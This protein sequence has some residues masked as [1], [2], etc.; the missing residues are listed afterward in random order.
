VRAGSISQTLTYP[1]DVVRRKMQVVGMKSDVYGPKYGSALG[2]VRG[3][4][5]T[6]GVRGLYR[7]LWANLRA[8]CAQGRMQSLMRGAVKVAPSISTSFF[9]YEWAKDALQA[10]EA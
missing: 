10:G 1:F 5:R 9:V 2:A 6:E 3:I 4:V 7:G 8:C